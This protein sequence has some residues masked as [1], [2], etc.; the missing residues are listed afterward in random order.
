MQRAVCAARCP[1]TTSFALLPCAARTH[2]S[3]SYP[4]LPFMHP[5]QSNPSVRAPECKAFIGGIPWTMNDEGLRERESPPPP[6][7]RL[8][9]A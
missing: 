6:P 4:P 1:P 7:C 2:F 3:S 9:D 8:L 5:I